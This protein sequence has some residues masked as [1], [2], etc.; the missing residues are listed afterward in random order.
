MNSHKYTITDKYQAEILR[1]FFDTIVESHDDIKIYAID[2][3]YRYVLFNANFENYLKQ[4]FD[5]TIKVGDSVSE[6]FKNYRD[7]KKEI[8]TL[9]KALSGVEFNQIGNYNYKENK[10][11][12]KDIY[13][14]VKDSEGN[15]L[16]AVVYYTDITPRK[17][18]E[19][20]L[21][22][23]LNIS[24]AGYAYDNLSDYIKY[25]RDE[26]NKIIDT[27]NFFVALYNENTKKYTFPYFVDEYDKIDNI[28]PL[29][30]SKS[31]T[32]Y[33]RRTGKPLFLNFKI[34][35]NLLERKEIE[36]IG[37]PSPF[38]IGIPLRT[39]KGI[40]GVMVAQNYHKESDMP[41]RKFEIMEFVS[42]HIA[43]A[44]ER[45]RD[46][47][48][49]NKI[50]I[51]L[52]YAQSLAKLGHCEINFIN[53]SVIFSDEAKKILGFPKEQELYNISD[54]SKLILGNSKEILIK[55]LSKKNTPEIQ[56]L[57]VKIL[58]SKTKKIV[59]LNLKSKVEFSQDHTEKRIRIMMQD[60]TKQEKQKNELK[61]AKEK[62]EQAD[63]LKSAFLAN[64]SHE[65]RTPMNAILGFSKLLTNNDLDTSTRE[66]YA[67]YI[68]SSGQNLMQLINDIIDVAKIEAGQLKIQK[69]FC[70][71]NDLLNELLEAFNQQKIILKKE[72]IELILKKDNNNEF[73]LFTDAVRFRQIITNLVGNALKFTEK[74]KI[75]F[76]YKIKYDKEVTF[77]VKDT[78]PG[79]PKDKEDIIFSRFGQI[80]DSEIVHPGGT[81]L[82]LSI[83]KNLVT[84]LGGEISLVSRKKKGAHFIFSLP[85]KT[86]PAQEPI[87][88]PEDQP[89]TLSE[90]RKYN[91]LLVEDNE[92]NR[93]LV[94][95]IIKLNAK[96]ITLDF[97]ET[98]KI[99][100][101]KALKNN[102]DL[103]FMDIKLP[104]ID[105]YQV[106]KYIR[107]HEKNGT[108]VPI[109][110]L[111]AHAM[112]E[113]KDIAYKAG[114]DYFLSKPF[115][116]EEFMFVIRKYTNKQ[117]NKVK[118][119]YKK[120]VN[121]KYSI[122]DL[123]FFI[124]LYQNNPEKMKIIVEQ[125]KISIDELIEKSQ[126]Y[127]DSD[128]SGKL[129]VTA[130][131]LK[132]S[133]KYLGM[134]QASDIAK[135]ME[136]QNNNIPEAKK[137][138]DEVKTRW[139]AALTEIN[140][141]LEN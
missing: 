90:T 85:F 33:V 70:N 136:E 5:I 122:I 53:D 112:K 80:I 45:N 98:G 78:G 72:N 36:I 104:D 124:P 138:L 74:G 69:G 110:A 4:T 10:Y 64:M 29:D 13:K 77:F 97:A 141:F 95:D 28:T 11:Y 52:Q 130:H 14:P 83:T 84:L 87:D 119:K 92:A 30:L 9:N 34:M 88:E 23:L 26:L 63:K 15:I 57:D 82:G 43:R 79:I 60:I 99:A 111:S 2:K 21:Q 133:F 71:I 126:K 3:Q 137:Y 12:Y 73:N 93:V 96:N 129:K 39:E 121:K 107:K 86:V 1:H 17:K 132:S 109:V 114:M 139:Q 101:I 118:S 51:E 59:Y 105:G 128:D 115:V 125:Y 37:T 54:L 76:G 89:E 49:M 8:A 27:K 106:T 116:F 127:V 94:N 18:N 19:Q 68:N 42:D 67:N 47:Y 123:S 62:A 100:K 50:T 108:R 32:D 131:T 25:I 75:I 120:M 48:R 56:E 7:L 6:I 46:Q 134:N 117:S 102:Y 22:V 65:I 16:G 41:T 81:G 61:L 44:V 20:V 135:L 24:E 38:W 58:N 103:I 35:R 55:L 31:T 91:I 140:D 113:L 40:I 66:K